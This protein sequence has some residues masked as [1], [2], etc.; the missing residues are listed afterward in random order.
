MEE[1]DDIGQQIERLTRESIKTS[2]LN[3][4]GPTG[5]YYLVDPQGKA[6]LQLAKPPWHNECLESPKAIEEFIADGIKKQKFADPAIFYGI[7]GVVLYYDRNDRR[8]IASCPLPFS[9]QYCTLRDRN[10]QYMTQ[11]DF[12]RMLRVT[13]HNSLADGGLLNILSKIRWEQNANGSSEMTHGKESLGRQLIASVQ[14][15]DVVPDELTVVVPM[16]EN[17]P[18]RASIKCAIDINVEARTFSLTPYPQEIQNAFENTLEDI[19]FGFTAEGFP[20]AFRGGV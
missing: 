10:G 13:F 6:E 11:K 16:F 14:G 7:K 12:I 2:T 18:Y 9:T 17:H 20:P 15:I 1:L 5:W 19:R 8:D 3:A 4:P